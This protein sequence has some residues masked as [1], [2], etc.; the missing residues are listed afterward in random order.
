MNAVVKVEPQD[1]SHEVTPMALVQMAVAQGADIDKLEKLM[2][3][4][5]RWEANQAR[6]AFVAAMADF[7][8]NPPQVLKDKLVDFTSQKGRTHYM[9]ATLGAM[10]AAI[11]KALADHEISHH[12]DVA[13][14]G[15][16]KVT[17]VLTHAA[18]HSETVSMHAN[19]DQ[20]GNKND[21]Q[22]IGSTVTYLQRYTLL[23]AT[24]LAAMDQDDDARGGERQRPDAPAN[25]EKWKADMTACADNGTEQ[26][27][28]AWKGSDIKLRDYAVKHD[29]KWWDET[30]AKAAQ[31]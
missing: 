24:G 29:S 4:Q 19:A 18:G 2:A 25:Y 16:I 31:P 20:T 9:H 14:N 23:A 13:Q 30:K 15:I 7:K 11:I 10:C 1:A 3:L 27:Q 21:I 6:K 8:A 5:E 26:L 28:T 12:W 22:A 17:C